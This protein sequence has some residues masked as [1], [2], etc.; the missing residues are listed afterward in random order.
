[1]GKVVSE[2]V[3][4]RTPVKRIL[5]VV[6]IVALVGVIIF[7]GVTRYLAEQRASRLDR[8]LMD[9]EGRLMQVETEMEAAKQRITELTKA[10]PATSGAPAVSGTAAATNATPGT[11]AATGGA[12]WTRFAATASGVTNLVRME[13]TSS[14]HNWQ[15]VGRLIGG[16]AEFG[17]GFPLQPGDKAKEGPVEANVNIFIP[18]RSMKSV[19]PDG[20]RYSSA[21][22]EIMYGKLLAEKNPRISFR[23]N[24]LTFKQQPSP[25]AYLYEATGSLG[26]A[27]VTNTVT[28][29]VTVSPK[30]DG[31]VQ[32]S[33]SVNTKMTDF[34]IIPPA[35]AVAG[36]AITTGDEV[37]LIFSWGVNRIVP[38]Q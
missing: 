6:G 20:D 5:T 7:L 15:V 3:E 28:M 14:M 36:G 34:K 19:Q 17:P 26:V 23:L 30:P 24:S 31:K 13:G 33:G 25:D 1:M 38:R 37:K 16:S 4:R 32:F 8:A 9:A 29:P 11:T 12:G 22:D 18:V 21:M 10:Q 35:P 27:G 2:T